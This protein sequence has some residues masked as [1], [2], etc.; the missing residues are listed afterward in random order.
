MLIFQSHKQRK[1]V[2]D[3][4]HLDSTRLEQNYSDGYETA[5]S[6]IE[7]LVSAKIKLPGNHIIT[8]LRTLLP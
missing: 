4:V 6:Q 2:M 3:S 7:N 5:R 1:Y 8:L